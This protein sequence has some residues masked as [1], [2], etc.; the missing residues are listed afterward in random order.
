LDVWSSLWTAVDL[1]ITSVGVRFPGQKICTYNIVQRYN[2]CGFVS[3][4][5]GAAIYFDVRVQVRLLSIT[6]G[7]MVYSLYNV[8][9]KYKTMLPKK[10]QS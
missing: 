3:R 7:Y 6:P 10:Y 8:H 4:S 5:F 2:V 9:Y 1:M